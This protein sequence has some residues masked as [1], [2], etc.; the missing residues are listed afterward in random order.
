MIFVA[1]EL[2]ARPDLWQFGFDLD[3]DPRYEVKEKVKNLQLVQD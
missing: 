2:V 3:Q 1:D